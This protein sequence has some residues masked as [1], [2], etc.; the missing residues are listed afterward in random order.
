MKATL[1]ALP[2]ILI[3]AIYPFDAARAANTAQVEFL[4]SSIP[5]G[6]LARAEA[7]GFVLEGNQNH[8]VCVVAL[9]Q[10]SENRLLRI[11]VIDDSGTLVRSEI[12]EDFTGAKKC[13]KAEL[14]SSKAVG[15]WTFNVFL[16]QKLAVTKTIEVARTLKDA[17]FFAYPSRPYVLGR[18]NYDPAILPMSILAVSFG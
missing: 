16:N 17:G 14:S 11:D 7:Y 3:S 13:Y 8:L 10:E 2:I 1:R 12:H 6:A 9:S 5:S 15:E 4:W 18:P